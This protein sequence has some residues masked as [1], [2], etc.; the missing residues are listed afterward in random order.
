[1][2][3]EFVARNGIIGL[4][5]SVISGSL[6]VTEVVVNNNNTA[7]GYIYID[8]SQASK[9]RYSISNQINGISNTGLQLRNETLNTSLLYFVASGAATF[10]SSVT[11]GGSL[12][13]PAGFSYRGGTVDMLASD[14]SAVYLK[15]GTILYIQNGAT[16]VATISTTGEATFS[17]SVQAG[18]GTTNASAILQADSTTKGFLPPRMTTTQRTSIATPAE[19]LI[20]FQTDGTI[21]LYVYAN[22]TWRTLAMV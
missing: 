4:K 14:G 1:M 19:G 17:S 13:I 16:T 6:T 20:V 11:T 21:G 3:N 10:S 15:T 9:N 12:T 7:P 18:G 2:P 5:D 8:G 22:S